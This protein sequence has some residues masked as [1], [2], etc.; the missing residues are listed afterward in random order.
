MD[1]EAHRERIRTHCLWLRSMEAAYA[2]KA[3][4]W[5]SKF[6]HLEGLEQEVKDEWTRRNPDGP[7]W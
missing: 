1:W 4:A 5:Y 2:R 7:S 3:T 6:P